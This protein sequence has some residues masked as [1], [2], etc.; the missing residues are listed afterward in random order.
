M[1]SLNWDL[2]KENWRVSSLF[3]TAL[4]LRYIGV[5]LRDAHRESPE[6]IWSLGI[7]RLRKPDE[8][9]CFLLSFEFFFSI[10]VAIR[11]AE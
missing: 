10:A 11:D 4:N 7:P 1:E 2:E 9:F 6:S 5:P 3:G 8:Y